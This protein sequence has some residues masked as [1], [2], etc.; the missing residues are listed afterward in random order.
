MNQWLRIK[1]KW[2]QV[3]YVC[4]FRRD[5]KDEDEK[6]LVNNNVYLVLVERDLGVN[7]LPALRIRQNIYQGN[8]Y[9]DTEK[10]CLMSLVLNLT[11]QAGT[12]VFCM[13]IRKILQCHG[14]QTRYSASGVDAR[15]TLSYTMPYAPKH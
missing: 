1:L 3:H 14:G 7:G 15:A 6:V 2:R 8:V 11:G 12:S 4:F 9:V 10:N 13:E 5:K